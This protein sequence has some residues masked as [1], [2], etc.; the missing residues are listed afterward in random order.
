[1]DRITCHSDQ[2]V[3]ENKIG[4]TQ[5][6]STECEKRM[7]LCDGCPINERAWSRLA[8][9]EDTGLLPEAIVQLKRLID[10]KNVIRLPLPLG[11]FVYAVVK[12]G[13]KWRIFTG[14]SFSICGFFVDTQGI[15]VLASIADCY[16]NSKDAMLALAERE[17]AESEGKHDAN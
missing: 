7:G 15:R 6:R 12:Q 2:T 4:C 16:S 5:F 9:Y 10:E 11:N 13:D 17:L 1:M 14:K 3:N 8:L